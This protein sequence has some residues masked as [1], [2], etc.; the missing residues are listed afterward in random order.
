MT[1]PN[2]AD[3]ELDLHG[4]TAAVAKKMAAELQRLENELRRVSRASIAA[5]RSFA[6][7]RAFSPGAWSNLQNHANAV[8]RLQKSY[9][10][11]AP[12]SALAGR[13][14]RTF[15]VSGN[16]LRRVSVDA[17]KT[18]VALRR[19]YRLKGGGARGALAVGGAV[20]RR[21]GLGQRAASALGGGALSVAGMAGS[22]GL[23]IGGAA[24]AGAGM[25]GWN[26]A[27]TAIEAERVK[28]ALDSITNGNGAQWWATASDYAKR[29]GLNVNAVADNLMN[30][31][32]SGFTD[33][34][35][36]TLFLRMGDLRSLGATEET[37]GRALLA[38]RQVQAAGRLQGD[39]LNQL[40]EAGINA[41]FIYTELSKTLH[42]T[43]PE[44]IKMK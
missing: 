13:A 24:A 44:I 33:D 26:M 4:N 9:R 41:N 21:Y 30:M 5:D 42:K 22:A 10:Q 18:E 31:K 16:A 23:A 1:E 20:N 28:F 12:A 2:A 6:R 29:F 11:L 14:L 3:F 34:M 36:K 32:A 7:T 43:V 37:I 27:S 15:G 17:A 40:S 38:I 25:L 19:L 39:E 35:T 8:V